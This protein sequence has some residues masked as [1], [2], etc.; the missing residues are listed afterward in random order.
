MRSIE[1]VLQTITQKLNNVSQ[2]Y[3]NVGILRKCHCLRNREIK[4]NIYTSKKKEITTL[5]SLFLLKKHLWNIPQHKQ[6]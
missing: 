2:V 3:L 6:L 5:P 4:N 1:L